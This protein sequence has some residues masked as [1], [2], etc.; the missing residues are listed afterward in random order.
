MEKGSGLCNLRAHLAEKVLV[1]THQYSL[2]FAVTDFKLQGR[3]LPKLILSLCRRTKLPHMTLAAFY[4]LVSRVQRFDGLRLLGRDQRGLDKV[5]YLRHD[6]YLYAWERGYDGAGH[7]NDD[8]AKA[9]LR[10]IR[11]VREAARA[12]RAGKRPRTG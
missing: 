5:R 11:D 7:W 3:T 2:S 12:R 6:A 10:K 9:A 4:V 1:L 8:L